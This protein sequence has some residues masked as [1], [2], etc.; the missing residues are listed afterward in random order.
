MTTLKLFN[1]VCVNGQLQNER[2]KLVTIDTERKLE[3]LRTA[4]FA[5]KVDNTRRI[6]KDL[7]DLIL[8]IL[9]N[10]YLERTFSGTKLQIKLDQSFKNELVQKKGKH[11][12][13]IEQA[14][15]DMVKTGLLI[16]LEPALYQL[17]ENIF[18]NSLWRNITGIELTIDFKDE[19]IKS[20]FEYTDSGYKRIAIESP[21]S[22]EEVLKS[23]LSYIPI[24]NKSARLALLDT[25]NHMT[26]IY[27][28]V[29]ENVISQ[30]INQYP[31]G[32]RVTEEYKIIAFETTPSFPLFNNEEECP[33][34]VDFDTY[35]DHTFCIDETGFL[36]R[37]CQ[38][39]RESEANVIEYWVL[40]KEFSNSLEME[41]DKKD[42]SST[43]SENFIDEFLR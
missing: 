21:N 32:T 39:E 29:H 7:A 5:H 3:F 22:N 20:N 40:D 38:I 23:L 35:V 24:E 1:K 18:G 34:G 37:G 9:D 43:E 25:I 33:D 6:S 26:P 4:L 8:E 10:A 11:I 13:R 17:N 27:Y 30:F 2:V 14:I 31:Y 36:F 15:T 28:I 42:P 12:T 19:S 16:R 41:E